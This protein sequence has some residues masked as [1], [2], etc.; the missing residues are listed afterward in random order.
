MAAPPG[1]RLGD[2]G[3]EIEWPVPFWS[4]NVGVTMRNTRLAAVNEGLGSGFAGP[5]WTSHGAPWASRAT[6]CR[7]A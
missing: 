6:P 5:T 1:D 4:M 2:D 3:S 7:S